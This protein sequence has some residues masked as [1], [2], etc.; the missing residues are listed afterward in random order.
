LKFS[1]LPLLLALMAGTAVG[2]WLAKNTALIYA[3]QRLFS[4]SA[5]CFWP[6]G[7]FTP[8]AQTKLN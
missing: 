7:S 3:H 1:G 4:L 6:S 2:G 8:Q 5:G